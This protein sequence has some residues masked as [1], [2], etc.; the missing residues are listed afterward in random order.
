MSTYRLQNLTAAAL[1]N[2]VISII[3]FVFLFKNVEINCNYYVSICSILTR[4]VLN[5]L[6]KSCGGFEQRPNAN[7][8]NKITKNN[9]HAPR[10]Q[11]G[12]QFDNFCKIGKSFYYGT[13]PFV[14]NNPE[15]LTWFLMSQDGWW[16]WKS[17]IW[18]EIDFPGLWDWPLLTAD[19][20]G[21]PRLKSS[22]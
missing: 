16:K 3:F 19:V 2:F 13:I 8:F 10:I 7:H 6:S 1:S 22:V 15:I 9:Q 21:V 18:L 14:R 17:H 5:S 12:G 11:Q 4:I 20:R